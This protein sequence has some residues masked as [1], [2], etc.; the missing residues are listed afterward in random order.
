MEQRPSCLPDDNLRMSAA[1][2]EHVWSLSGAAVLEPWRRRALGEFP[3]E[4]RFRPGPTASELHLWEAL[5]DRNEGWCREYATGQYRLDFYLPSHKLAVEIDGS[6]HDGPIRRAADDQGDLWHL[7]RFGI[8]TAR[9]SV[10]EVMH[11]RDGVLAD[12]DQRI[13]AMSR[14]SAVASEQVLAASGELPVAVAEP[15]SELL[16]VANERVEAEI[17][18][19]VGVACRTILPVFEQRGAWTRMLKSV[20]R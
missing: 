19:F 12:I 8:A 3:V 10:D 13:A 6:S 17:I 14:S 11:D 9:Y 16:V 18:S 15:A 20:A 4:P 7:E 2:I 1:A 5:S